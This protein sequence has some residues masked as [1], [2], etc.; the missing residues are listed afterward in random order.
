MHT[1]RYYNKY[2]CTIKIIKR[3]VSTLRKPQYKAEEISIP[4]DA[5]SIM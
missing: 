5:Q 4:T 1:W 3:E 2:C